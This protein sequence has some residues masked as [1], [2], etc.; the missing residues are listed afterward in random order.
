MNETIT[1][2][3]R[4]LATGLADVIE[5][6]GRRKDWLAAKV[7]LHFSTIGKVASRQRTIGQADAERVAHILGVPFFLLF[8]LH[9]RNVDSASVNGNSDAE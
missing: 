5:A 6:Q 8:E 3:N 9:E 2:E 4:Y 7:G 1:P